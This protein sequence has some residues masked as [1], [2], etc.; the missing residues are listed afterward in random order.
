MSQGPEGSAVSAMNGVCGVCAHW[1]QADCSTVGAGV[2]TRT[3][4]QT[5]A[6]PGST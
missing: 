2:Y 1:H 5:D 4:A 6:Q 3:H